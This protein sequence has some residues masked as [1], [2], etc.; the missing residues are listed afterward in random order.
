VL[1]TGLGLNAIADLSAVAGAHWDYAKIAWGSALITGNLSAKL[2]LYRELA[3]TPLLGGTLF[4]YALLHG[5]IE[6][7]LAFVRD[8]GL[9]IEISDGVL[10]LPRAEKLR[11]IARFARDVDV[12]S[13]VGKKGEQGDID[14]SS[15][16]REELDAG[17][18]CIV[19]EG[20]AIGPAGQ[21]MREDIFDA[22]V[23]SVDPSLLIFEALERGQQLWLL[24]RLGSDAN[25]ANI[26]PE[27]LLTLESF[28]RGL[29]EH[30]LLKSWVVG[31]SRPE[32][33]VAEPVRSSDER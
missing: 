24:D 14:W 26:R 11:W 15:C 2:A 8:E 23:A 19:V 9:H 27:H 4:E 29:K 22:L 6:E 1:D 3:I 12:F 32:D 33:A 28:R 31:K 25:L 13:E 30:T 10:A 5:L 16:A 7:L 18:R 20:R 17:A 21:P